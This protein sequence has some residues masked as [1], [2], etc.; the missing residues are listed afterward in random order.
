MSRTLSRIFAA[1]A[2]SALIV[3]CTPASA[4]SPD[5]ATP[6]TAPPP[7]TVTV[8]QRSDPGEPF[9]VHTALGS[10]AAQIEGAGQ[11]HTAVE[12]RL[13]EQRL[14]EIAEQKAAAQRRL[15]DLTP[16]T[17]T[18]A[19]PSPPAP[20]VAPAPGSVEGIIRAAAAEFGVS[21]DLLV[22]IM[23]C[24][25]NLNPLAVNLSSGALGLG[26]HLP[27]YWGGRAAALGYPYE[28]W[29]DPVAN[30]RVSAKL[31]AEGGPGHW[32]ACL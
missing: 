10:V 19:P 6:T 1:L 11:M 3:A 8:P 16:P 25:S 4:G 29:S 20:Q 17:P 23:R 14:A 15:A 24:E 12:E 7:P 28:A 21:G 18:T 30:A 2:L 27:R 9:S 31:M 32:S 22:S 13:I 5:H 26:Q